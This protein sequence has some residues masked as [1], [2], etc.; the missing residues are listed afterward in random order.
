MKLRVITQGTRIIGTQPVTPPGG[1]ARITAVLRA[2][3]GQKIHEIEIEAPGELAG[4]KAIDAFHRQVAGSL[5]P[6]KAARKAKK[7]RRR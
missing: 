5:R 2:G 6:R 7:A 1:E 4:A 3:P